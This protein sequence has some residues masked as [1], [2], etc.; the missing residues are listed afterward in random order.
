MRIEYFAVMKRLLLLVVCLCISCLLTA[1]EFWLQP[2]KYFY[3]I[4]EIADIKF[5]VG[6][7]FTGDNWNG[8]REKIKQLT[9]YL[10]TGSTTDLTDKLSMNKGDSIKLPLQQAGTHMV[11]FNSTNSFIDLEPEKF[12]AYLEEDG[13]DKALIYRAQNNE[14]GKNGREFYQRSVK[15]IIQIGNERTNACEEPTSLPLDII[16]TENPYE[17]PGMQPSQELPTVRF[18]VLFKG[19]AMANLLVKTWFRNAKG[20]IQMETYRTN[21]RGFISA[22]RH[23]GPFMVSTVYMERLTGDTG[24]DWQSY[25]ASV[26]FEYSQFFTTSR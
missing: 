14:T 11:I 23:S 4:R 22:K 21:N 17:P 19:K 13:L 9:H 24:A 3:T 1:H 25:W 8:N 5:R 15:T 7:N 20:G 16:P 10:P 12:K 2:E 6:E 26:N 18:K